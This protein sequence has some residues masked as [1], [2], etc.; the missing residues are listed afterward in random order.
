MEIIGFCRVGPSKNRS[1]ERLRTAPAKKNDKSRFRR[2]LQ[3]HFFVSGLVFCRFWVPRPSPKMA[4]KPS[5]V[6]ITRRFF[7]AENR[8]L[9]FS[10][11]GRFPEGSRIDS[12]G[13]RDPSGPDFERIFRYFFAGCERILSGFVEFRRDVA[14]IRAQPQ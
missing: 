6:P 5:P 3:T 12:G 13:S 8:F 4:P 10:S 14:G 7:A 2:R 9:V 1:G 11:L